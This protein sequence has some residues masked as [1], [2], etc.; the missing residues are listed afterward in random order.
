MGTI[1]CKT[2]LWCKTQLA[3]GNKQTFSQHMP[4]FLRILVNFLY[5]STFQRQLVTQSKLLS[6]IIGMLL[7]VRGGVCPDGSLDK[8]H[9]K[10]LGIFLVSDQREYLPRKKT[11]YT[12]K[13][14]KKPHQSYNV[15]ILHN[16]NVYFMAIIRFNL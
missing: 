4:T 12:Y 13:N 1:T 14:A 6:T 2:K 5:F 15:N 9:V 8:L 3:V 11:Q 7:P 10:L 16:N